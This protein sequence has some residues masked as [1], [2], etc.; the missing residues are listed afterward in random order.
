MQFQ[1]GRVISDSIAVFGRNL[2]PFLVISLIIGIPYLLVSLMTVAS[3]DIEA[4]QA[5]G[6]LPSGFWGMIVIGI[7]IGMLTYALTQAALV[8]GTVQDL[9][10]Q[11]ASFGDC[12]SRG[13]AV[14]PRVLIVAL[15]AS[16]GIWIGSM[17]LLVPGLILMVM[18]WIVNPVL[19]IEG[20][21]VGQ[22][23]SRSRDLTRGHRWQIFGI[24]VLVGLVYWIA[25]FLLGLVGGAIGMVG[26]QILSAVVMLF[27]S[28]FASVLTAVGYFYL[29]AEK[30]GIIID[31]LAK[32]FD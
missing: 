10:G 26:Q 31:D 2:G 24:L 28:A 16:L 14:L 13:F 32:V 25:S 11:R 27:F 3:I 15:L 4:I 5:T 7:L 30:E 22:A 29:R 12:L 23:F 17:L 20:A 1:I 19:V 9:R 8:Y 6:Q 21:G 18:W